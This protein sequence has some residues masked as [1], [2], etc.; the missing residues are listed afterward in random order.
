MAMSPLFDEAVRIAEAIL[1]GQ[2]DPNSGCAKI[3][4]ICQRLHWPSELQGFG[5]LAHEQSGHEHIGITAESCVADIIA[6]A[7]SLVK[8]FRDGASS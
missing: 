5:A 1:G 8:R 3:G 6:E 2:V 4:E 7:T